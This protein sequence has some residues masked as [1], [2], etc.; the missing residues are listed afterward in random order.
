MLVLIKRYKMQIQFQK[1]IDDKAYLAEHSKEADGPLVFSNFAV[2]PRH[3]D[4]ARISSD[5]TE[6]L[7]TTLGKY[8]DF[9]ESSPDEYWNRARQYVLKV[10]T[11][12]KNG[13]T[14]NTSSIADILG[15]IDFAEIGTVERNGVAGIREVPLYKENP[16]K[17]IITGCI[18][19]KLADTDPSSE[20]DRLQKDGYSCQIMATPKAT[21]EYKDNVIYLRPQNDRSFFNRNKLPYVDGS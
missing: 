15:S 9:L 18:G 10:R 6:Q 11:D 2:I 16:G 17:V 4:K 7:L 14:I 1:T 3:Y 20:L 21:P 19:Y 8:D 5:L 13:N 12:L